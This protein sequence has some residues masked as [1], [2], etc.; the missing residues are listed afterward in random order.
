VSD[1]SNIWNAKTLADIT[2]AE[3]YKR[4]DRDLGKGAYSPVTIGGRSFTDIK[5]PYV[6]DLMAECFGPLGIGWGFEVTENEYLG[7]RSYKAKS[8]NDIVEH[9]CRAAI[10]VWVKTADGHTA[11][12]GPVSGGSKNSE[13]VYAESGAITNAIGKSLSF[14]GVQRHIYK[15]GSPDTSYIAEPADNAQ[16]TPEPEPAA[17]PTPAV[18][19]TK[20]PK[21]GTDDAASA[22]QI[23]KIWAEANKRGWHENQVK[24]AT[25]KYHS[26]ADPTQLTKKEAMLFIDRMTSADL[27]SDAEKMAET[28][29]ALE[30]VGATEVAE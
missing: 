19:G 22:G 11:T 28:K 4:I 16:P 6:Y 12:W 8:G 25:L 17:K 30:A 1:I 23:R 29:A 2:L 20:V 26:K 13:R 21:E 10:V 24:A 14:F 7:T 15:N 18:E 5:P 3:A 27:K 9:G